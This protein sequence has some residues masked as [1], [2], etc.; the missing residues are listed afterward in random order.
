MFRQQFD[1]RQWRALQFAPYLILSGVTGRYRDF[2]VEELLVFERWLDEASR[3]PGNLSREVL[4][5]VSADAMTFADAYAGYNVTIVSG[6]TAVAEILIGQPQLEVELF[7][8]ALI[9]VLGR[10]MARAR[11]PYGKQPT[12]DGEQMLTM[13]DEFLRPGVVFASRSGD[14]A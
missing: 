3:A 13:L 14:A 8:D 10:G 7:R 4:G 5:P 11:G 2:G 1:A 12:P 6:L 9:K